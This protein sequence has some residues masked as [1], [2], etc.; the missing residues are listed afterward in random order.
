MTALEVAVYAL[1][2]ASQPAEFRCTSA[3]T[4][5]VTYTNGIAATRTADGG[6]EFT[7]GVTL[8]KANGLNF[9]NG[10]TAYFDVGG[11]VRFSNGI[12]AIRDT[13]LNGFRFSNGFVCRRL[14]PGEAECA[15]RG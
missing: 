14:E 3:G 12:A 4:L 10:I 13:E 2:L 9:S 11:W 7:N 8:S 5:L 1:V 15:P 6:M